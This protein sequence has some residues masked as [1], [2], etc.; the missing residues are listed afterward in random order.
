MPF[1]WKSWE[2]ARTKV[3][4]DVMKEAVVH[5]AVAHNVVPK[6][7][8]DNEIASY[9]WLK[10]F[11][12]HPKELSLRSPQ[13]TSLERATKKC[14][15][16]PKAIF[17]M[18]E[19]G[20]T[21]VNKPGKIISFKG[22]E[23]V[24]KVKSG[25]RG[26]LV[27]VCCAI[28]AI[29]TAVP[30][31]FEFPTRAPPRSFCLTHPSS[32]MTG[33]NF[34]LYLEYFI[35]FT[36]SSTENNILIVFDNHESHITPK[37]LQIC[38]DSGKT[39]VTLPSN[40]SLRQVATLK[41]NTFKAY[42]S[43][44]A[45][46]FM[47]TSPGIPINIYHIHGLVAKSFGKAFNP[48]NILKGFAC[49]GIW[50]TNSQIFSESDFL[51]AIETFL[52]GSSHSSVATNAELVVASSSS[53]NIAV[54]PEELRDLLQ[55]QAYEKEEVDETRILTSTPVMTALEIEHALRLEKKSKT[56][57]QMKPVTNDKRKCYMISDD[58]PTELDKSSE[59]PGDCSE[60]NSD[61]NKLSNTPEEES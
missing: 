18:Y 58:M 32:W 9:V 10:G 24:G 13:A 43:I 29:G 38:K 39:L 15:L 12:H 33:D 8:T 16:G 48:E 6:F 27:T 11:M 3:S 41:Q 55:K 4:P 52:C 61:N 17:N 5:Y 26:T 54:S 42:Y 57:S 47:H 60:I 49:T 21:T 1:F 20:F 50:P 7:W 56:S 2:N 28:N 40:T 37:G 36:Q 59:Y 25:E 23:P 53:S 44:A 46:D 34:E 14:P 31:V 45:D 22:E 51:A 35:K 30:P 19:T